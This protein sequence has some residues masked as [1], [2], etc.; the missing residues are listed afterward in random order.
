LMGKIGAIFSVVSIGMKKNE[1]ILR[2]NI[3]DFND[4]TH[5]MITQSLNIEPDFV[6]IKGQKKIREILKV[7]L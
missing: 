5:D 2:F 7:P 4:V 1:L 6:R 3:Y